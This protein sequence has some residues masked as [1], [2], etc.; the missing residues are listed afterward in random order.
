MTAED[1]YQQIEI[2]ANQSV[3][4]TKG[5]P[6]VQVAIDDAYIKIIDKTHR[7][8]IKFELDK[9]CVGQIGLYTQAIVAVKWQLRDNLERDDVIAYSDKVSDGII[10]N[11]GLNVKELNELCRK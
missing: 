8:L 10:H 5:K 9:E 1:L 4:N 3:G 2:L 6:V 7:N 11:L